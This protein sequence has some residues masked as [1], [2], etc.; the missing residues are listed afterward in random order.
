LVDIFDEVEEDLR[1]ERARSFGRRYGGV[2]ALALVLMLI[3]TG[4]YVWWTQR[5]QAETDMV[6]NRFI[7]AGKLADKAALPMGGL[8][9]QEAKDAAA[10]FADIAASGPAGYRVLARLRLAA[11][12]WQ[13][14]DQKLAIGTWQGVTD[15]GYAPP[16]LRDLATITS[17]QHQV[18]TADPTL[19][20]QTVAGLTAPENP[21]RPLAEQV[22]ALIDLRTGKA[23]EAADILRRLTF[24]PQAPEGV[25][26]MVADL[27]TTLP[28]DATAPSPPAASPRASPISAPVAPPSPAPAKPAS[29]G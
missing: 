2:L 22:I 25:R 19:L 26:Q 16:L 20:K 28:A 5:N 14:G 1:A 3:G 15:D 11:L 13:L 9:R 4:G 21:W 8:D 23:R 10:T 7:A 24:D 6:A 17:A 18:D 27:L 29:H 12:Q